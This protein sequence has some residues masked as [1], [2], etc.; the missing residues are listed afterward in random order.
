MNQE[1]RDKVNNYLNSENVESLSPL[2]FNGYESPKNEFDRNKYTVEYMCKRVLKLTREYPSYDIETK[3][4]E[5]RAGA[6]RSS[7][8]IWRHI[9][10]YYSD[11]TIF[12]IMNALYNIESQEYYGFFCTTICRR[13]FKNAYKN[14]N[15]DW[16]RNLRYFFN[17]SCDEYGLVWDDWKEI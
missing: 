3:E 13:I 10:Y 17:I 8:D 9:K 7:L 4:I 14:S 2:Y 6:N 11:I 16:Q 1:N 15:E 12:D 5:C